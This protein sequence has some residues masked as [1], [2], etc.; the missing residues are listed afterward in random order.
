MLRTFEMHQVR[1]TTELSGK[2][3]NFTPLE[4]EQAGETMKVM[5]PSCLETYPGFGN[6][7]GFVSYETVFEAQGNIRLE[8]KGVSHFAR[9]YVDGK[10][11]AAHYGSYTPFGVCLKNLPA[12]EHTLK[13]RQIMLSEMI[14]YWIFPTIICLM[15]EFPEVLCW[16]RWESCILSGYMSLRC[17]KKTG[18]GRSEQKYPVT[19][20]P[21]C[22]R[23]R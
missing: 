21:K 2:L 16:N 14:M 12:G 17:R 11:E 9:I 20:L 10:E 6:Y 19:I 7:R 5:V 3:W 18:S 22:H 15:A 4:G 1:K 8:F 13:V 23:R